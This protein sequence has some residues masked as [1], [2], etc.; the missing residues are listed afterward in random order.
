MIC[1]DTSILIDYY[2]KKMIAGTVM[3]NRLPLATLNYKHF[4]RIVGL[5]L[6]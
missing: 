2:R 6:V 5:Q 1:L 4:G 3:R